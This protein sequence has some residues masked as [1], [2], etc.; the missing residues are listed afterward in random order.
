MKS[1]ENIVSNKTSSIAR[2]KSLNQLESDYDKND[3]VSFL[4]TALT[5]IAFQNEP[6]K[7][8]KFL[9]YLWN[10]N[11]VDSKHIYQLQ[12]AYFNNIKPMFLQNEILPIQSSKQI[13][14]DTCLEKT[15]ENIERVGEGNFGTVFRCQHKLDHKIYA[16]KKMETA[17]PFREIEILSQLDHPNIVRYY[18]CWKDDIYYYL[19]MQY[20]P[21]NLKNY[22]MQRIEEPK[23]YNMNLLFEIIEGIL[24]LHSQNLI[25]CDLKPD[26]ILLTEDYQIKI[27]DFGFTRS[28]IEKLQLMYS[29]GTVFYTCSTDKIIDYSVDIYSLGI[30]CMEY[31]A[32]SCKTEMEKFHLMRN[33]TNGEYSPFETWNKVIENCLQKDQQKRPSIYE[34]KN[35]LCD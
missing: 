15:F 8:K 29:I 35:L 24:Y 33:I 23:N 3:K 16:I 10:E 28:S 26:N 25:H 30:I 14:Q 4:L 32:M 2:S 6:E 21:Q 22:M 34:I 18:S 7:L 27:A 19:Q 1:C 11:L 20:C 9:H 13:E 17:C 31:W 5:S 12:D